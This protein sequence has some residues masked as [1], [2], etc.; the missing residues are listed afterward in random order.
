LTIF[1][2][3]VRISSAHAI[4]SL[5][6]GGGATRI[7]ATKRLSAQSSWRIDFLGGYVTLQKG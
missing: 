5:S 2:V 6:L 1:F 3:A 7:P 4:P